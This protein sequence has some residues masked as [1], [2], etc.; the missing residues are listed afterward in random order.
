MIKKYVFGQPLETG[1]VVMQ[2]PTC[3]QEI[4]VMQ[5]EVKENEIRLCCKMDE[6]DIVYGLGEQVRGINKRGFALA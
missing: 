4:S 3:E 6:D 1:A 2:I 5:L